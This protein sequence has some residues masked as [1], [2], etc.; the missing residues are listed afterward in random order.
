MGEILANFYDSLKSRTSGYA[1]FDYEEVGYEISSVVKVSLLVNGNPIDA[2]SQ[3]VHSSFGEKV[4]KAS[5]FKL[6]EVIEKELFEIVI[7]GKAGSKIV[8]R[9][10]I[11][12]MRKDVTAKLYGG[13]VTRKMKLLKKQA[14]GKKQMKR[15]G[16]VTLSQDA[17]LSFMK[18]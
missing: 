11:K 14:E 1:S 8:V 10:T 9:E 6:K 3:V 4:A 13:D 12:A 16:S 15:L 17:F 18:M 2:L 7:Q 5:V